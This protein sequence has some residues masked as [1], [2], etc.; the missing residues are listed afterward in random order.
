MN[1]DKVGSKLTAKQKEI[2]QVQRSLLS[3]NIVWTPALAASLKAQN[4]LTDSMIAQVDAAE[5]AE[6]KILTM[7]DL[8]P[9]R[10]NQVYDKFAD[11]LQM[12]GHALI[13]DFLR[14]EDLSKNPLNVTDMFRRLPFLSKNIK[15]QERMEIESYMAEMIQSGIL[16]ATWHISTKDK[17]KALTAKQEQIEQAYEHEQELKKKQEQLVEAQRQAK[18]AKEETLTV[19]EELRTMT[20]N[21]TK[22]QEQ[23]KEKFDTQLKFS[24]A[25]DSIANRLSQ[26]LQAAEKTLRKVQ[27]KLNSVVK[28]D[29]RDTGR[30]AMRKEENPYAFLPEDVDLFVA[31]FKKLLVTKLQFEDLVEERNFVLKHIGHDVERSEEHEQASLVTAYKEFASQ[32]A[33]QIQSLQ[34]EVA[35]YGGLLEDVVRTKEEEEKKLA[36]AGTVWQNAIMS[37]MRKQLQDLKATLRKKETTLGIKDAEIVKQRAN[38]RELELALAARTK[39]VEDM[40]TSRGAMTSDPLTLVNGGSPLGTPDSTSPTPAAKAQPHQALPPLRSSLGK[41]S[42]SPRGGATARAPPRQPV[43]KGIGVEHDTPI[44]VYPGGLTTLQ[45]RVHREDGQG[46]L[47]SNSV[48]TN[49]SKTSFNNNNPP[50]ISRRHQSGFEPGSLTLGKSQMVSSIGDLKAM[51]GKTQGPASRGVASLGP[52]SPANSRIGDGRAQLRSSPTVRR[53]VLSKVK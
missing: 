32:H 12:A 9:L 17:D 18:E 19:K 43:S 2:L 40:M 52:E 5:K 35:R 22:L 20:Q 7:L 21:A 6:N 34:S 51:H 42:P 30:D 14:E 37:V 4:L 26:R 50:G 3:R 47:G 44:T 25:N 53:K 10:T 39:E 46:S 24:L 16:N 23:T 13:A 28:L 36:V 31:Q 1:A 15:D 11:A 41:A 33:D 27:E 48:S 45:L 8:L 29:P 38:I 49:G